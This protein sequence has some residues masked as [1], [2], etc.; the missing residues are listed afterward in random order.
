MRTQPFKTFVRGLLAAAC[1]LTAAAAH[2]AFPERTITIVV[3]YAP[4]GAAD[5]V[6]RVL[7]S[8]MGT[9]LGTSVIV[10]NKP[11]ASGTIGAAFVAKAPADGY[12]MLYDATPYSINPHLFAKMPYAAGALQPLS[13][14]LLAPN[15]LIVKA[16]SPFKT[17]NDLVARAK[18]QPGR[19]NFASGGSGTV[20]RLASELFRQ[21]LQLDMV[22]V[23]YKSGG[24]AIA[25]V[26]G[27]QVDFMFGTIA[28]TYPLV[29]GGKLRALAISSP[30]RSARLPD[31]PTVAEAAVPGYEA[32][33]WNGVLLPA[34]TPA[35]VAAQ[36][37]KALAEV[38][39]EDEVKQRLSDLGARPIGSTPAE[40]AEFL[41]K[42]DAKWGAVVR[43]GG[44]QLD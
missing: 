33:E 8:R 12:T 34:G 35:S 44:I 37:H 20:Q 14:V 23:P 5:A 43:Q 40:F 18:A 31:V 15:V 9:R 6:A 11:G 42:E 17:V 2:A 13:L 21:R 36:L 7:A 32:Y 39:N 29:S 4:G 25:D 27:G 24:P 3:P 19:I 22:H 10:D 38:L 41:K 26:M 30:E 1:V 16:D 28:A